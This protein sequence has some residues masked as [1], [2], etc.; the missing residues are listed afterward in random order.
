MFDLGDIKMH[1]CASF[2]DRIDLLALFAS[3]QAKVNYKL[4]PQGFDNR[5]CALW[6]FPGGSDGKESACRVGN[7]S[8]IT[9]LG[10][11]PGEG[12]GYCNSSIFA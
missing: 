3:L 10:T 2:L 5:Y 1:I 8:L 9:G 12:N 4:K 7:L 6:G 11:S